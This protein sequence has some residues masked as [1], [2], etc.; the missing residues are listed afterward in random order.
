MNVF[1]KYKVF[2]SNTFIGMF[3]HAVQQNRFLQGDTQRFSLMSPTY[4]FILIFNSVCISKYIKA[5]ACRCQSIEC[6]V[7]LLLI[8]IR[9][10]WVLNENQCVSVII[11][12][13]INKNRLHH[14]LLESQS[15]HSYLACYA[16]IFLT[17]M[18]YIYQ[19]LCNSRM[20]NFKLST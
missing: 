1:R 8:R 11:R 20:Q 6:V 17:I 18:L 3:S 4:N 5:V 7:V 10:E 13:T 15:S 16:V 12:N 9:N 14:A 2:K 19:I